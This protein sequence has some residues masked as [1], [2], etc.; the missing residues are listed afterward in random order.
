M[1]RAWLW[2]WWRPTFAAEGKGKKI[3]R[4]I[5]QKE[6]KNKSQKE[7][8]KDKKRKKNWRKGKI[9]MNESKIIGKKR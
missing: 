7:G 6:T 9:R 3:K 4:K 1:V 5:T 2:G 8:R